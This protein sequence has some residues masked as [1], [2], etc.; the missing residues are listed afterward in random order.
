MIYSY[1]SIVKSALLV[2]GCPSIIWGYNMG[3]LCF[4]YISALTIHA[5][6]NSWKYLFE[7]SS[8]SCIKN[9]FS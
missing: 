2:K 8:I 4:S 6:L 1:T 7:G 3:F 9:V 5:F